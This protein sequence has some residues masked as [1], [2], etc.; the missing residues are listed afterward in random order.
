MSDAVSAMNGASFNGA[1]TVTELGLSGMITLRGDLTSKKLA[2]AVKKLAGVAVPGP[3]EINS[4]GARSVAWMSPDELL[5]LVTY[6]EAEA[7]AKAL[8]KALAVEH[9]LAVN[10]SDA[11]AHFRVSGA[12]AREVLGK[13]APVDLSPEAFGPGQIRRTRVGQVASAFWMSGDDSFDVVCF[14]SVGEYMFNW[15]ST[16]AIEGS[17]PG[18]Y[19]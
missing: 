11:R 19:A 15:L 7:G 3:R 5:I 13:G 18:F 16:A 1:V 4:A 9:A 6:D 14:R 10:V 8:Q 17:L 2:A 12:G